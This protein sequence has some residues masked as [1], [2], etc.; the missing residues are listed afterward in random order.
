MLYESVG[1]FIDVFD[2]LGLT[3]SEVVTMATI[4]VRPNQ[5]AEI[6]GKKPYA[7]KRVRQAIADG[8]RQQRAARTGLWRARRGRGKPPIS[9][10]CT[11][12]TPRLAAPKHDPAGAKALMEE[13]GMM[14]FEHEILSIDDDWRRNTTDAVAAQLR[15][16]GFKV[17]RTV[18]P[19]N[20]L[21]ERLGRNTRSA[22][23][24]G[25]TAR[26][27][28]RSG[29]WPTNPAKPGTNSAGPTPSSTPSSPKPFRLQTPRSAER[30]R[31]EM[32]H[33]D[34]GG[35]RDHPAL[36]AL[37]LPPLQGR[38]GRAP[39]CISPSN[40]TTTNGAWPPKPNLLRGRAGNGAAPRASAQGMPPGQT[41]TGIPPKR[42]GPNR[43]S[44][45]QQGLTWD[46]FILRRLGVMLLT[47]LCL[48][49][50]VFYLTNLYPNLEK[51]AKTQG[52]MR[53]TDEQ[54]ER[55][56]GNRGYTDNLFSKY[57]QWLGIVPGYVIEGSDGEVRGK[58]HRDRGSRRRRARL[59]AACSRATGAGR[60]GSAKE[61]SS[62]IGTRLGLTAKL[63]LWDHA[64]DGAGGADRRGAGG[65]ARRL[66]H[67]PHA[68]HAVHR[69]HGNAGICL[70][71]DLHRASGLLEIRP[72][73]NAGRMGADRRQDHLPR[74]RD[75]GDG[76]CQFQQLLPAGPD[77]RALRHGLYRADD[78]GLD[79]RGDDRAIHPHRAP[80]RVSASAIS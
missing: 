49:F 63:M 41:P 1:E 73:A 34:P 32:R 40:I 55:W 62:I 60:H 39:T 8:G 53:M 70:G 67:R 30:D 31:R 7:D 3:K 11:R 80:Q 78:P 24:T 28:S 18:L 35:R 36:L 65:D 45:D 37:A 66:A 61:V 69:H 10:R 57:G 14:D 64:P 33:A 48:T 27:A 44:P 52:N 20:D 29:R 21:L 72:L 13:A 22:R 25:T 12:N 74:H 75:P 50:V 4:V 43:P 77:H 59:S 76:K 23:P 9:A 19:G 42:A 68:L 58:L 46:C 51:L 2:G 16:A 79:G 54:V 56:L 5:L 38:A 6:D 15:D 71:R 17:K 47:A 26:S